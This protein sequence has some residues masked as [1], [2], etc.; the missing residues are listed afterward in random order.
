MNNFAVIERTNAFVVDGWYLHKKDA[1][2]I[3]EYMNE[4][5]PRGDWEVMEL[6]EPTKMSINKKLFTYEYLKSLFGPYQ[7][8]KRVY[9]LSDAEGIA[10]AF[11]HEVNRIFGD[12]PYLKWKQRNAFSDD[13][14]CKLPMDGPNQYSLPLFRAAGELSTKRKDSVLSLYLVMDRQGKDIAPEPDELSLC[15]V[16]YKHKS[17]SWQ[18]V[19]DWLC[20]IETLPFVVEEQKRIVIDSTWLRPEPEPELEKAY[21]TIFTK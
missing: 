2:G 1:E 12:L 6:R 14:F 19:I 11:T 8:T 5:F 9:S 13:L 16:A 20:S 4:E 18:Q 7:E 21:R 10:A 17:V 3:V 15:L